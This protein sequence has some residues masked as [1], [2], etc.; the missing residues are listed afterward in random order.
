MLVQESYLRTHIMGSPRARTHLLK[1]CS[2]HQHHWCSHNSQNLTCQK[3]NFLVSSI[4]MS[5]ISYHI[6]SY[7][8]ISYTI[9][10]TID[11]QISYLIISIILLVSSRMF[12]DKSPS[13]TI[14]W[15]DSLLFQPRGPRAIQ[16]PPTE[17]SETAPSPRTSHDPPWVFRQWPGRGQVT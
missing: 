14:T 3:K 10:Y 13:I 1:L 11:V 5:I 9:V 4:L 16:G 7:H 6:I 8:I 2:Y 12:V 17:T 15:L